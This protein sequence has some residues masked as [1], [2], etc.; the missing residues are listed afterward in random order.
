MLSRFLLIVGFVLFC[1]AISIAQERTIDGVVTTFEDIHV[2]KANVKV[3]RTKKVVLTDTIGIFKIACLPG[4]KI[5]VSAK[6]FNSQTF[7]VTENTTTAFINLKLKPNPKNQELA[8]AYGHVKEGKN[9]NAVTSVN[10]DDQRYA[11]FYS[12]YQILNQIPNV[13]VSGTDVIIRGKN[14]INGNGAALIV[15]DRIIQ[16]SH[17]LKN[18][19]PQNIKNVSVLKG[20]AAS[21]YGARGANGVILI[22]TKKGT[23]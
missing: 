19:V 7:R 11:D 21:S 22:T 23:D 9:L 12:V 5:R 6:G 18:L 1:S 3:V 4:D 15:V 8:V 17:W 20:V 2:A 13:A 14:S 16:P 10:P